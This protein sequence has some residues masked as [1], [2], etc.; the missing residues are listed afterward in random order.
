MKHRADD[1]LWELSE[2]ISSIELDSNTTNLNKCYKYFKSSY[3]KAPDERRLNIT[4]AH[5]FLKIVSWTGNKFYGTTDG[6]GFAKIISSFTTH[7]GAIYTMRHVP[8]CSLDTVEAD[9]RMG[10]SSS[11]SRV[12]YLMEGPNACCLRYRFP[13]W[14]TSRFRNEVDHIRWMPTLR[15]VAPFGV[16]ILFGTV[17][18]KPFQI[19]QHCNI[20]REPSRN[21]K[22]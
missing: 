6:E 19:R 20:R 21:R 10:Y 7:N 17:S 2:I 14:T 13:E 5:V 22:W 11:S 16:M 1:G 18:K 15:P 9:Q 12:F 8:L 4:R 3:F